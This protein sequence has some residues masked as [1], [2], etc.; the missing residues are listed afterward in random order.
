MSLTVILGEQRGDEG[1]GRFV[2]MFAEEHDIVARFNGGNNA[3]HTVVLPD[4]KVLKLHQVPSGIAH[5][6]TINI[7]GNGTL[8]NPIKLVEEIKQILS[9]GIEV[10]PKNLLVSSAV[11]LILPDHISADEIREAGN[12]GQGSTKSGIAQVASDKYLRVG[13]R[14]EIFNQDPERLSEI[15]IDRLNQQSNLRKDLGLEAID[16][17]KIANEYRQCAEFL[18]PYVCD[19]VLFIN[20]QIKTNPSVKILAEGAQA[21]LL[22]IDHGMYPYTTSSSTTAG[23][24]AVGIGVPPSKITKVIGVIKAVQ[25]HVGGGEF[26]TEIT[27]EALLK[28]LHGDMS[29]VD[30]ECGTT[31]GRIRRLG[32]LDLPIIKRA[33]MVN[34]TD[35][36]AITKLDWIPRYGDEITV[37]IGYKVGDKTLEIAPAN[38]NE[39]EPIYEKLPSWIE[40]ITNVRN[41]E[42]L[43][44][45]A[46][47]YIHFIEDK[48][49]VKVK[50]IGVGPA[51]EQ[52][53]VRDDI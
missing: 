43:P 45:N 22:D 53:I 46:Q 49:G 9:Q 7:I 33:H 28:K 50:Y 52:V 2:D 38:L 39:I 5:K 17:E 24:V 14:A 48:T 44:Q 29:T 18:K 26:V 37:C 41:F 13:H 36:I 31:T 23:G 51:R 16:T 32:H 27:D 19:T 1:K 20:E 21:F 4:S 11:H 10:S 8:L 3:G 12:G 47:N 42:D 40:D 25:S 6:N 34:G 35:Y 30:A 15:I